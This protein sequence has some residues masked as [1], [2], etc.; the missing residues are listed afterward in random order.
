M[1]DIL[2]TKIIFEIFYKH[3]LPS[4]AI[5]FVYLELALNIL[6]YPENHYSTTLLIA[7]PFLSCLNT[8]LAV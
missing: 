2:I 8:L 1:N 3:I 5:Y 6:H 4:Y 7:P